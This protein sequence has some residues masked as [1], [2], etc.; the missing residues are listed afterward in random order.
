MFD[1]FPSHSK[2]QVMHKDSKRTLL[3]FKVA[4]D[5]ENFGITTKQPFCIFR[6]PQSKSQCFLISLLGSWY[7]MW[8]LLETGKTN[9]D[10]VYFSVN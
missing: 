5:V 8:S 1:C 6:K 3:L 4:N 7:V 10:Q 2:I 9:R